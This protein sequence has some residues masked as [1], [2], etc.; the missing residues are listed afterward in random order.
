[1]TERTFKPQLDKLNI[2]LVNFH[3]MKLTGPGKK[4]FTLKTSTSTI[5]EESEAVYELLVT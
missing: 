4:Q 1:M 5:V 2:E 3:V